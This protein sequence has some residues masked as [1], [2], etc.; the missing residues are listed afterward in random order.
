VLKNINDATR[1]DVTKLAAVLDEFGIV[2]VAMIAQQ[3]KHRLTF[4]DEFDRLVS[5]PDTL[6]AE[7]HRAIEN[8]LWLL[9]TTY[10][11]VSSNKSLMNLIANWMNVDFR[12]VEAQRRPDLFLAALNQQTYLLIEF[13]R[14]SHMI[15]RDDEHQANKYRDTLHHQV[16]GTKIEILMLG[17]GRDPKLS[18]HYETEGLRVAS[19]VELAAR[20]REE[21]T[22]LLGQ[23]RS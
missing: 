9:G 10:R 13:K 5:N 19:F 14:P 12:D 1:A 8:N 11:L 6:E 18:S 3:A 21:L 22:W 7:V 20:A 15:T 16:P 17:R 23:L 2:D 4:L